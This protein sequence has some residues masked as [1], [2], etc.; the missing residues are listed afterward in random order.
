MLQ[1]IGLA[2]LGGFLARL[3]RPKRILLGIAAVTVLHW[4]ILLDFG[5]EPAEYSEGNV[6]S[7]IDIA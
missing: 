6:A 5:G 2:I 7:K 4:L 3:K 1:R